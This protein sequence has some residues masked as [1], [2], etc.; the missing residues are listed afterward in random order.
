MGCECPIERERW[1]PLGEQELAETSRSERGR[2][3][4]TPQVCSPRH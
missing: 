2:Y 1:S 4:V 3:L